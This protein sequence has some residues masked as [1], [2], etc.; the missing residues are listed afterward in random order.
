MRRK[1]AK[2][3][4]NKFNDL[5]SSH[6]PL[7][8]WRYVLFKVHLWN[9]Q[10]PHIWWYGL[11][12]RWCIF[13]IWELATWIWYYEYIGNIL[14]GK[15][16]Y[17]NYLVA[18]SFLAI[19]YICKVFCFLRNIGIYETLIYLFFSCVRM[20]RN[21]MCVYSGWNQLCIRFLCSIRIIYSIWSFPLILSFFVKHYIHPSNV[22]EEYRTWKIM[23]YF[24]VE[25]ISSWVW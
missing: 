12:T 11:M 15:P 4:K 2:S 6:P 5:V 18:L 16:E 23:K 24:F 9:S 22:T 19:S 17:F 8:P 3:I 10:K 21:Q 1:H 14:H 7:M 13:W 20:R 25:L